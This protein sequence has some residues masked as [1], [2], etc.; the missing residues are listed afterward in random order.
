MHA[1]CEAGRF[2]GICMRGA[3]CVHD[4]ADISKSCDA[5]A[6]AV[7]HGPEKICRQLGASETGASAVKLTQPTLLS[8]RGLRSVVA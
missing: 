1:F 2:D 8:Q 7:A 4:L 6:S 3:C 5:H